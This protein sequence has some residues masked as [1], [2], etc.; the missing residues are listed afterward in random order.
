MGRH[1][2]TVFPA[3][4]LDDEFPQVAQQI[5]ACHT[6]ALLRRVADNPPVFALRLLPFGRHSR[7]MI[8]ILDIVSS[9]FAG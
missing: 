7:E 5:R 8:M 6:P 3:V 4:V 1:A 9:K 2:Q